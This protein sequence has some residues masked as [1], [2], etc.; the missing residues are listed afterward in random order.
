MLYDRA[1]KRDVDFQER[2]L[3]QAPVPLGP[4]FVSPLL[5]QEKAA[6]CPENF[7]YE[8]QTQSACHG[9]RVRARYARP[10]KQASLPCRP[11]LR[12]ETQ[13]PTRR[14]CPVAERRA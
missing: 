2:V 5:I 11:P 13:W 6:R 9:A 7:P 1:Q 14:S 8:D 12:I 3:S 4:E 10:S